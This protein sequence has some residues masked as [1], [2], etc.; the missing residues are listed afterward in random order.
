MQSQPNAEYFIATFP[1][2]VKR[3]RNGWSGDNDDQWSSLI[4]W[5]I[6]LHILLTNTDRRFR[7]LLLGV[8]FYSEWTRHLFTSIG[9]RMIYFPMAEC[10]GSIYMNGW[11]GGIGI[12]WHGDYLKWSK[13][14][15]N[16]ILMRVLLQIILQ[17][18]FVGQCYWR[19]KYLIKNYCPV[20]QSEWRN[21][22][23]N[24]F[25]RPNYYCNPLTYK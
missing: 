25:N 23:K 12:W 14:L 24:I 3:W 22:H 7:M 10:Q 2:S 20:C 1:S 5:N 9:V 8:N 19:H 6:S 16:F 21:W 11:G 15:L 13:Y 17:S 4:R 18:W